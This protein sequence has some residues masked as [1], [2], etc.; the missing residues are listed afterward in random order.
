[1]SWLKK[2]AEE[3][4]KQTLATNNIVDAAVPGGTDPDEP[5]FVLKLRSDAIADA[6]EAV[7]RE[8]AVRVAMLYDLEQRKLRDDPG[9]KG[10]TMQNA[11]EAADKDET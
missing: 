1:M 10:S 11:I 4:A 8:F 9:Y 5:D 3:A 2:R 7:A 6:I